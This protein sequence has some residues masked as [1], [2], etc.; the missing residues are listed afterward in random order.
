MG[1]AMSGENPPRS[2]DSCGC[3][4][5]DWCPCCPACGEPVPK[6]SRVGIVRV[7][8]EQP[9]TAYLVGLHFGACRTTSNA[10]KCPAT[11]QPVIDMRIVSDVF[12]EVAEGDRVP[13][14]SLDE[15]G[16]VRRTQGL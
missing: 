12:D 2:C 16:E 3:S 4:F 15:N 11:G 13:Y 1:H 5:A 9:R 8:S 14:Y 10:T 7:Y 6:V